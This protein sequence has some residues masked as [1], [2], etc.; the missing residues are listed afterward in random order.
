MDLSQNGGR[1]PGRCYAGW[2]RSFLSLIYPEVC[3][4]CRERSAPPH[5]GYVCAGCRD[6]T[7]HVQFIRPPRCE[8]CGLPY[9]GQIERVF[10]CDNCKDLDLHFDAARAAVLATPFILD[11]IHRYKYQRA[12]WFEPF[13]VKL[14]SQEVVPWLQ[15]GHWDGLVPVPLHPVRQRE[16]EFNQ[17]E[18][19]ARKLGEATGLPVLRGVVNRS[20]ATRSQALL[21][22][23]ERTGN[24]AGAFSVRPGV[25]LDGRRLV[26][27]D[28]VLTTGATTSAV[29]H[30]LRKA[31]AVEI[32]V[33][34]LARGI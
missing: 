3:E 4:V 21:D 17:A 5:E 28:D 12:L 10:Q 19:L 25:R 18:R 9:A 26:V 22:R 34:T 15:A 20:C 7:G 13:F 16:R 11:L 14:L 23:R 24:V 31:G 1:R 33:W 2:L 30:A 8:L 6:A 29:S 27:V 32:V